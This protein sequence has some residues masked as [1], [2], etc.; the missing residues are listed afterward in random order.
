MAALTSPRVTSPRSRT[1]RRISVP[2]A[3]GV[4][5]YQGAA[6]MV[7]TSGASKGYYAPADAARTGAVE[8]LF[9]E[10][11]DNTAGHDGD[12]SAIVEFGRDR[13][14]LPFLNDVGTPLTA[15]DRGGTAYALDDQT[16]SAAVSTTIMGRLFELDAN[17]V[18]WVECLATA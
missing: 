10:T 8:G 17:G 4:K 2:L 5:T 7:I 15:S 6:A 13:E 11:V 16:V 18:A 3:A 14:L 9:L 1:V 12:A